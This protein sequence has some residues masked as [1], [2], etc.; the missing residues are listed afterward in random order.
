[1]DLGNSLF[2]AR[3]KSGLSQEDVAEKLGVSRQTISKWETNETLPD[4]HQAKKMSSLYHTT[5]DELITFDIDLKEIE[6][7][8][9]QSNPKLE[10]KIDWTSAWGKKYP[11]L[12]QYQE[13]V[14]VP[15]YAVKLKRML[16]D[17]KKEYGYNDLD[18]FLVLKDILGKMWKDR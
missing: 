9:E 15:A 2:H 18:A 1:M 4:V 17:L 3:K 13:Q 10:A 5:L 11:I 6:Q 7:V 8:I 16:D 14:N 12:L